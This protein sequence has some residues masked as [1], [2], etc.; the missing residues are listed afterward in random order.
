[1][2][3]F[4]KLSETKLLG[5]ILFLMLLLVYCVAYSG[6]MKYVSNYNLKMV[7]TEIIYTIIPISFL[8]FIK[9]NFVRSIN[10]KSVRFSTILFC[11]LI[12]ICMLPI[13]TLLN[14]ITMIFM[15]NVAVSM[16]ESS[17]SANSSLFLSVLCMGVITGSLEEITFRGTFY[18]GLKKVNPKGAIFLSALIFGLIHMNLNQ[19]AYATVFGILTAVLIEATGSIIPGMCVHIFMN[20]MSLIYAYVFEKLQNLAR[21]LYYQAIEEGNTVVAEMLNNAYYLEESSNDSGKLSEAL[22]VLSKDDLIQIGLWYVV[23]AII[24]GLLVYLIIRHLA[25][26]SGRWDYLKW[27]FARKGKKAKYEAESERV[28]TLD[29]GTPD[30]PYS[31][32]RKQSMFSFPLVLSMTWLAFSVIVSTFM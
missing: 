25:K 16:T 7:F 31:E 11:V 23:P 20:S 5:Y 18:N 19:F 21:S 1:M 6:I 9:G 17:L 12:C 8:I 24:G 13:N 22:E 14:S 2:K 4:K 27:I 30:V 26:T 32:L 29:Y 10:L 15:R 3:Y 28:L